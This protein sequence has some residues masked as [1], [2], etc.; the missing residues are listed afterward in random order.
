VLFFALPSNLSEPTPGTVTI[1]NDFPLIEDTVVSND[2]AWLIMDPLVSF[3]P[4]TTDSHNDASTRQVLDPLNQLASKLQIAVTGIL[5]F[6]K[7][8]T[9]DPYLKLSGSTAFFN[10]A[11]SVH[12]FGQTK[13]AT[14]DDPKRYLICVKS[15]LAPLPKALA[16]E[17]EPHLASPVRPGDEPANTS[18][19]RFISEA[20]INIGDFF[21]TSSSGSARAECAELLKSLLT[22]H[23][24]VVPA[25]TY[26]D[27]AAIEIG[28]SSS[29]MRRATKTIGAVSF[30]PGGFEQKSWW[31]RRSDIDEQTATRLATA[32]AAPNVATRTPEQP[33]TLD[34]HA[35]SPS[36]QPLDDTVQVGQDGDIASRQHRDDTAETQLRLGLHTTVGTRV[37]ES[38]TASHHVV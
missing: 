30:K 5:H 21:S 11:R 33:E 35:L 2:V 7:A 3:L 24:G 10:A 38:R 28:A 1:P 18:R 36:H 16:Y 9:D 20:E 27:K 22:E 32:S 4:G 14:D 17:V 8:R 12:Y 34:T 37:A 13:D 29:T 23:G 6:N 31:Y 26:F 25:E 19:L 15:N